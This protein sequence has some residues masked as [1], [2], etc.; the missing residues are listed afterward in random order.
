MQMQIIWQRFA[1]NKVPPF[2]FAFSECLPFSIP[3]RQNI[4]FI[5]LITL[6]NLYIEAVNKI[7]LLVSLFIAV[8]ANYSI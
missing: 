2:F 6:L 3:F 5:S 4:L 8:N 7:L 1:R